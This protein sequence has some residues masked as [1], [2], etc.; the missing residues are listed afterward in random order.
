MENYD[1]SLHY[2]DKPSALGCYLKL[3]SGRR[4]GLK[5]GEKLPSIFARWP[6][7]TIDPDN[8]K[9]YNRSC[10]LIHSEYL[11]PLYP[12]IIAAPVHLG[13]VSH[14]AFPLK[15]MGSIHLSN[16]ILQHKRI[17]VSDILNISCVLGDKRNVEK[18]LEFDIR[19][20][21]R[22][23]DELVWESI[24]TA[25]I[26][27]KFGEPDE[28]S[29]RSRLSA[30]E[31]ASY[32]TQWAVPAGTG[33]R[34]AKIT[35]DFN[36]I[37]LFPVTAKLFGFKRDIAHGMWTLANAAGRLNVTIND[38]PV[39]IDAAFKGPM[40]MANTAELHVSPYD[41]GQKFDV[42]CSGNPKP[43]ICADLKFVEPGTTL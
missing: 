17:K 4:K 19:T 37:H 34:Y 15:M 10:G 7:I 22:L 33:R 40:F 1:I 41:S 43:V 16:H 21:V 11:P 20:E 26:R 9:N 35:G 6:D 36:P 32:L 31:G 14:P 27:G 13:M 28:P 38:A 3:V 39:K 25:L 24:T 30:A 2:S 42:F 8:L 18:G 23:K 29:E 12:H 5:P